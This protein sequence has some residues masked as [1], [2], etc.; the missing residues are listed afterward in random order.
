[1]PAGAKP[2]ERRGGRAKGTPNLSTREM[3]AKAQAMGDE[4]LTGFLEM[5]KNKKLAPEARIKAGSA[6]LDRGYGKPTQQVAAKVTSRAL[7]WNAMAPIAAGRVK[8]T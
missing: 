4:V 8:T 7:F 6:I 1:M 3:K 2:G 5:F